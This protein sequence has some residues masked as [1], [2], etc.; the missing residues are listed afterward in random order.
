MTSTERIRHGVTWAAGGFGLAA[1]AYAS[2]VG[3]TWYR[4]GQ[5]PTG[6]WR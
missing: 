3:M 6:H 5:S 4:Y 1:V 2:Y